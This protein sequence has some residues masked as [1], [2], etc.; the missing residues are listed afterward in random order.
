[1]P[2]A[3]PADPPLSD[4][5]AGARVW[6]H[7]GRWRVTTP[8]LVG[9]TVAVLVLAGLV[10][11]WNQIDVDAVH[12]TMNRL[13]GWAVISAITL[14]PLAGIPVAMLH[15]VAGV[16]FGIGGGLVVVAATTLLQHLAGWALVR[17]AP[18]V[19]AER[20]AKWRQ[21]FPRGAH[22]PI[23]VFCCVLPGMPYSIQLYLL[24]VLGVPLSVLV[25][26]SVPLHVLRAVISVLMGDY[27]DDLTPARITTLV[28]Y[29]CALTL[30]STLTFRRIKA[31]LHAGGRPAGGP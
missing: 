11:F 6:F 13:P 15:V 17:I 30:V 27:S 12:A 23:T 24:P 29:Y 20:L 1:M 4:A 16:R 31:V 14:A 7:L 2:D 18:H 25:W 21:R 26:I 9:G 5:G 19:F 22:T 3:M 10:A 8:R 28:V